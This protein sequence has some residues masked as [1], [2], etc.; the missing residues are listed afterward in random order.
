[1]FGLKIVSKT[2]FIFSLIILILF[3]YLLV[4]TAFKTNIVEGV[5]K[6]NY[7]EIEVK[8]GDTLWNLAKTFCPK[9]QDIRKS[10]YEINNFNQLASSEIYPGQIIKIPLN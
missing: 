6:S 3:S 10:I 4:S 5:E 1:M 9:N 8:N 2:R 7:I